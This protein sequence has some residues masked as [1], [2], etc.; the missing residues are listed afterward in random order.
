MFGCWAWRAACRAAERAD[1][2]ATWEPA[3]FLREEFTSRRGR[4][5]AAARDARGARARVPHAGKPR[6]PHA[7]APK[8]SNE[9]RHHGA[10]RLGV[11]SLARSRRGAKS[12]LSRPRPQRSIL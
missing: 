2:R 5:L 6:P 8:A 9:R 12:A 7:A 10:L 3:E 4:L 11:Q 1:G